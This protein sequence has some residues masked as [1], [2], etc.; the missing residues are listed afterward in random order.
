M[1]V[2]SFFRMGAVFRNL[3][4]PPMNEDDDSFCNLLGV[5]WP[6]LEKL[7]RSIHIESSNLSTAACRSLSL[8]VKSSGVIK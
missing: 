7:F 4:S 8:A 6:L 1:L 2:A 5:L 3:G